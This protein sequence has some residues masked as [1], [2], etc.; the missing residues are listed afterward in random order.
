ML[1][2]LVYKLINCEFTIVPFLVMTNSEMQQAKKLL[3]ASLKAS[4][5]QL[6]PADRETQSMSVVNKLI[7]SVAFRDSQRI[8]VYL[9]MSDEIN[10]LPLVKAIFDFKKDCFIPKYV[11]DSMEMVRLKSFEEIEQL[12]KTPWNIS[13]PADDEDAWLNPPRENALLSG[14]LDLIVVPGLGFTERGERIGRGKG[15]YD[16]FISRCFSSKQRLQPHLVALAFKEQL[17]PNIP[18]DDRD[19]LVDAVI[20]AD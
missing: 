12:P 18:V 7:Q 11:G 20:V 5:R 10:T 6:T 2:Y 9:P 19:K 15:F 13:Q 14:G 17:C 16:S 1:G 4:L 3:R 8:S